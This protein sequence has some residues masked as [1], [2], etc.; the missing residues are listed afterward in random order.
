[1]NADGISQAASYPC[2]SASSAVGSYWMALA[3]LADCEQVTRTSLRLWPPAIKSQR[4]FQDF[5]TQSEIS[6]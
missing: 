2:S 1:M 5:L 6:T 3:G 4:I